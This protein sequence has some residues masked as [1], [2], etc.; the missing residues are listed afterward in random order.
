VLDKFLESPIT[1]GLTV[2][3]ICVDSKGRRNKVEKL[4]HELQLEALGGKSRVID[5]RSWDTFSYFL[6]M[7]HN[8][9]AHIHATQEANRLYDEGL[10]PSMLVDENYER[11]FFRDIIDEIIGCA[12]SDKAFKL[13]DE[14]SRFWTSIIGSRGMT[15]KRAVNSLTQFDNLFKEI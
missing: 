6:L 10:V 15:G 7:A 2:K 3:D 11:I 13:I 5:K 8:V 14:Y 1:R 4:A 12:D 9:W